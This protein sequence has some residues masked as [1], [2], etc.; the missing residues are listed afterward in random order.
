MPHLRSFNLQPGFKDTKLQI[1]SWPMLTALSWHHTASLSPSP[2]WHQLTHLALDLM[3]TP[4]VLLVIQSCP[5]LTELEIDSYDNGSDTL[6]LPSLGIPVV[7]NCLRKLV[8][9]VEPS[10]A[11]LLKRLTLPVLTDMTLHFVCPEPR[12]RTELFRFFTR[13]KC[14]LDRLHLVDPEFDDD[15]LLM[16]LEHD[17]CASITDLSLANVHKE[18]MVTDAVLVAL[19][20]VPSSDSNMLLPNLAH[21]DFNMCL[22]GSPG[23][24]GMMLVSRCIMW[25]EEHQLKTVQIVHQSLSRPDIDLVALAET[26]GLK[27]TLKGPFETENLRLQSM[28]MMSSDVRVGQNYR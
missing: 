24:L 15:M 21:L 20:D 26:H 14:K 13:S 1:S 7:N 6:D 3:T 28:Q 16:C 23:R 18:P 4:E 9:D 12:I 17:S 5:K 25:D 27:V 10:C 22:G 2:P 19:T 11:Q 8:L